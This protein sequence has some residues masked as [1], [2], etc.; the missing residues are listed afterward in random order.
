LLVKLGGS[1]ITEKERPYTE[2]MDVISRLASEIHSARAAAGVRLILG[3]GG[4]SYPHTP[5]ARYQ[6]HRGFTGGES[7]LGVALVQDA[8]SRLNRVVV[9]ALLD[10]GEMAVSVQPSAAAI[11]EY[12]RIVRWDLEAVREMV[13]RGLI[14]VV[15]GDVVMD[16]RQGCSIVST[17]EVFRY[18]ASVMPVDR[19]IVGTDVDGV[20]VG[21]SKVDVI[22]PSTVRAI[23]A[24]LGGA[25]KVDVTGGMRM[26]VKLLLELAEA[27]VECEVVNASKPGVLKAAIKGVRNLGTVISRG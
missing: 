22:T 15:Y 25:G 20:M 13:A 3:H 27:G 21:S 19:V 9:K 5:A 12:S 4:G 7:G 26:K 1:V 23:W 17:E 2:R 18:M 11:A 6:V 8:A 24:H 10:V 16:L 14:P